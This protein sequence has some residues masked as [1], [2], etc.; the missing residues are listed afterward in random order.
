[1]RRLKRC[2]ETRR[3]EFAK[4]RLQYEA[5]QKAK[6]KIHVQ[7]KPRHHRRDITLYSAALEGRYS[8]SCVLTSGI[9][10]GLKLPRIDARTTLLVV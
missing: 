10:G 4:P 3:Q 7:G 5:R 2:L 8:H 9:C 6:K 1:M